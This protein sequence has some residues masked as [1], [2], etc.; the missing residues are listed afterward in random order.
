MA[1]LDFSSERVTSNIIKAATPLLFAQV[2][3]LLYNIVDR[4]YIARIPEVGTTALG[5]VGL[6][7]PVIV[8]ISAFTNMYGTGGAPLFSIERGKGNKEEAGKIMDLSFFLLVS[9]SIILMTAGLLLAGPLL[10]LFGASDSSMSFSMD[11]LRIYLLGTTFSMISTGMNPFINAQGFPVVGMTTVIIG[12]VSNII[13]DPVFI[14]MFGMGVKG[15]ALATIISQALSCIFVL[16][17]LFGKRP[18]YRLH[19]IKRGDMNSLFKRA[20]KIVYLGASSF[21]MDINTS[22]VQLVSNKVLLAYG[23]DIYLSVMSIITSVRQVMEVPVSAFG[24][25]TSPIISYNYGARSPGNIKKAAFTMTVLFAVYTALAW[26]FIFIYP[27]FFI[28]IFTGDKALTG[29]A[30]PALHIYFFAFVFMTF[31][32]TGQTMF[33]SLGKSGHAIFFSLLRKVILVIPLT[34]LLPRIKDLGVTGVFLA[35]PISNVIGGSACFITMLITVV[36]EI[37]AMSGQKDQK[38]T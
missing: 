15:A 34:I 18:E 27:E 2:L 13:L 7:F 1:Q 38:N 25:G 12:A 8:I 26:L 9:T 31:Q 23:G 16:L 11:Y 19:I 32:F 30:V 4:I 21:V 36:P 6:A 29:Y 5:A 3:N 17:F 22:L 37:K 10:S 24:N 35:E 20:G 28:S 14:F 33:K